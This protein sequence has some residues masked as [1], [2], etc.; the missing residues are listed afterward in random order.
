MIIIRAMGGLGNQMQQYALYKKLETLGR[1]VRLD[2]SCFE[3]ASLQDGMLISRK[4]ELNDL[5]GV[6]Y[7]AATKDEIRAV[8]GRLWEEPEDVMHKIKRKLR[9]AN[10][11]AFIESDMYHEAVFSYTEKYLVGYWACEKYYA[12]ILQTL[13]QEITFPASRDDGLWQ[14]NRKAIEEMEKTVSV[15]MHIRRGDYL[16]SANLPLFGNICKD[17]YYAGAINYMKEK[18]G[19]VRFYL[20]SDDAA[21]ARE[22]YQGEEYH[23]IDWNRGA[24]S[25]YDIM[26]MSHCKHNICAN[27]TFSFW[28]ARLNPHADKVMIRPSIHKNTQVCIPGQMK[29]LWQG[30]TL[31]TPQGA[32]IA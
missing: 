22:H 25:F 15:S 10:D 13:R 31:I 28:G 29:D 4:L 20:F 17:T 16:D 24:D 30:W 9:L 26:L 19:D 11:P 14:K 5:E 1:D 3:D 7:K 12:D 27:S 2:I 18:F 32:V 21:Y 6:S 8:L 23:V